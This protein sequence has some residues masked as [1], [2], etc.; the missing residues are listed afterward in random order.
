MENPLISLY[1]QEKS[2]H[3]KRTI[4]IV[5]IFSRKIQPNIFWNVYI[6]SEWNAEDGSTAGKILK[7]YAETCC[8]QN[9]SHYKAAA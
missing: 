6:T 9:R 3:P 4:A 5:A 7:K 1:G 8:G 2:S